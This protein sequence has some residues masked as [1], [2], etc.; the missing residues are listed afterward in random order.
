MEWL[1]VMMPSPSPQNDLERMPNVI[2]ADA[3]NFH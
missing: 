3:G 2:A 1:D